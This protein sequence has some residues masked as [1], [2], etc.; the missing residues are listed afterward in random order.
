MSKCFEMPPEC[1]HRTKMNRGVWIASE[2]CRKISWLC[3]VFD[4]TEIPIHK[5]MHTP[6]ISTCIQIFR[7]YI[8]E[9]LVETLAEARKGIHE[10]GN[11]NENWMLWI[12]SVAHVKLNSQGKK[13][14]KGEQTKAEAHSQ[15]YLLL[16]PYNNNK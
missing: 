14:P 9:I 13:L 4:G 11:V 2:R 8:L 1:H 3:N 15:Q 12:N 16:R 5:Y 10:G 6:Y 7:F